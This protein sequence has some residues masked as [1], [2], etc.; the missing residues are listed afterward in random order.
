M[1]CREVGLAEPIFVRNKEDFTWLDQRFDQR[2]AFVGSYLV[3]SKRFDRTQT[4]A[5]LGSKLGTEPPLDEPTL[6]AYS[7]W[8]LARLRCERAHLPALR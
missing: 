3:G 4:S 6:L 1:L 8:Y 7:R 5:A 2:L